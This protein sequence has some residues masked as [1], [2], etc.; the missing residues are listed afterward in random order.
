[1]YRSVK[2]SVFC[3][4]FKI[5]FGC[6]MFFSTFKVEVFFFSVL[7]FK[8]TH[9]IKFRI[10]ELLFIKNLD[11]CRLCEPLVHVKSEKLR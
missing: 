5:I 2:K 7:P 11:V 3:A 4:I 10:L 1:M 9:K 8:I 6:K